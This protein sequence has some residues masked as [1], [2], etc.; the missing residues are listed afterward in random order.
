MIKDLFEIFQ[1]LHLIKKLIIKIIKNKKYY[2]FIYFLLK[3]IYQFQNFI[4][5]Y[6]RN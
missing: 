4:N 2:L 1:L 3:Y 5:N 6:V